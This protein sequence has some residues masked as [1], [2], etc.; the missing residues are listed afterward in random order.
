MI[1]GST[2]DLTPTL[3]G[4]YDSLL[5]P[6]LQPVDCSTFP[7]TKDVQHPTKRDEVKRKMAPPISNSPSKDPRLIAGGV[8]LPGLS[9]EESSKETTQPQN[10]NKETA[11]T[12]M[13]YVSR[14]KSFALRKNNSNELHDE[15]VQYEEVISSNSGA[16]KAQPQLRLGEKVVEKDVSVSESESERVNVISKLNSEVIAKVE[17]SRKHWLEKSVNSSNSFD[18]LSPNVKR[19]L[20]SAGGD[21]PV[22]KSS[23]VQPKKSGLAT[24]GR[25]SYRS[26]Q[27]N[28]PL[29]GATSKITQ[30]GVEIVST[31]D[32][33][34]PSELTA[35]LTRIN[36][37][38]ILPTT[39]GSS[40]NGSFVSPIKSSLMNRVTNEWS[41]ATN[42]SSFSPEKKQK[43]SANSD[44]EDIYD[45]PL[46]SSAI[47]DVPK[48][49]KKAAINIE[50]KTSE[51]VQNTTKRKLMDVD[52][53]DSKDSDDFV[54]LESPEKFNNDF[55]IIDSPEKMAKPVIIEE[56]IKLSNDKISPSKPAALNIALALRSLGDTPDQKPKDFQNSRNPGVVAQHPN[57]SMLYSQGCGSVVNLKTQSNDEGRLNNLTNMTNVARPL[58]MSSI[59]SSSSTSSSGVQNKG[60]NSAYLA[61]IESLDDHSDVDNSVSFAKN[62]R[63]VQAAEAKMARESKDGG[64]FLKDI[65]YNIL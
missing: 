37:R 11:N 44:I 1:A 39:P 16:S 28:I 34:R 43:K 10:V 12:K 9:K 61:S 7:A 5:E 20:N 56:E 31:A 46:N 32:Y 49:N 22:P 58:S 30:S 14:F 25:S 48:S 19:M 23:I 29:M 3:I 17:S 54:L 64:R 55:V 57:T 53:N 65:I 21:S 50:T 8:K 6:P 18:N 63:L 52:V 35:S 42:V 2:T 41:S 60:V 24:V 40:S 62:A 38:S 15:A 26:R 4:I 59:A 27:S 45:V 51:D 33:D 36:V 13:S 47:Y